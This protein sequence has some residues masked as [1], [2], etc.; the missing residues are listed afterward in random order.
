MP[1][2]IFR[3]RLGQ[4]ESAE[5]GNPQPTAIGQQFF[6]HRDTGDD[7]GRVL[8]VALGNQAFGKIVK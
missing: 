7:F 8:P 4:R 2:G 6:Q 5:N 1:V 3:L